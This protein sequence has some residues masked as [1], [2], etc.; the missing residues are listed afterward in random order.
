MAKNVSIPRQEKLDKGKERI[1]SIK[2]IVIIIIIIA[3]AVAVV[4]NNHD[5]RHGA[6]K[7]I[8]EVARVQIVKVS[9]YTRHNWTGR[10][11]NTY[12]HST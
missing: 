10:L 5:E 1:Q 3:G 4:V 6:R 7:Q 8:I 2:M 9:T 12:T 11:G